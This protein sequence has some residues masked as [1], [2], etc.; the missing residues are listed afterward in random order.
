MNAKDVAGSVAKSGVGASAQP[1]PAASAASDTAW[2]LCFDIPC[3]L[4]IAFRD[5]PD[6]SSRR[7]SLALIF[8]AMSCLL[9]SRL[10]GEPSVGG[11]GAKLEYGWCRTAISGDGWR[12]AE[13]RYRG[14]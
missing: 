7:T 12:G 1:I 5:M 14:C 6:P 2:A 10:H 3:D 8:L 9:L 11:G 13:S 4:A